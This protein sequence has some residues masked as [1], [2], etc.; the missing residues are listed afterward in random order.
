[1][2]ILESKGVSELSLNFEINIKITWKDPDYRR[3]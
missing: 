2:G 3:G 1:M